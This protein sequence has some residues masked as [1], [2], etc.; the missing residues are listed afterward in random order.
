MKSFEILKHSL[1][2]LFEC[3]IICTKIITMKIGLI[4]LA[5]NL[6]EVYS[7]K[8]IKIFYAVLF[9]ST[10]HENIGGYSKMADKVK[11]LGKRFY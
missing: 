3:P 10:Q 2:R 9:T 11:H 6:I 7:G 1:Q 4:K 5:I 8:K